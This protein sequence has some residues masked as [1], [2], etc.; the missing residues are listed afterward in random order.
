[1]ANT[2]VAG[3]RG[4]DTSVVMRLLTRQPPAQASRAFALVREAR[5]AGRTVMVTDLVVAEAYFALHHHYDVPKPDAARALL[6]LLLSGDALPEPGSRAIQA[7]QS[8]LSAGQKPGFVDRLIH[9]QYA[10][11]GRR[12]VSFEAA[13]RKLQ[14]A[15]VLE[16]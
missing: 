15:V 2:D 9:A 13:A 7:L 3:D 11:L 16:A 8:S 4:L 12:L 5:E 6:A 10:R 14:D 1:M